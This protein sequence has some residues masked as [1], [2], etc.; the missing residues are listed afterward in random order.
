M[1]VFTFRTNKKILKRNLFIYLGVS[2][3]VF[4]FGMI[5]ETFS[6]GVYSPYMVFAF[7]IPLLGG[8]LPYTLFFFINKKTHPSE[9]TSDLYNAGIATLTISSIFRGVLEIYGTTREAHLK[10]L[11]YSGIILLSLGLLSYIV[12]FIYRL[13]NNKNG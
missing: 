3:F 9:I 8:L 6:H 13:V 2:I 7:L 5:Y 1:T 12:L 4:I 10:T 11:F